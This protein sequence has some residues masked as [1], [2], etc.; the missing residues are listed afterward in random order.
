MV[1]VGDYSGAFGVY[2]LKH[3]SNA[4]RA[5]EQFLSDTAPYGTVKRLRS[6]NR[7]EYISKEFKFLLL[8]NHI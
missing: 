1:F 5:T 6:D 4:V 3:K 8:K 7:G 2:F